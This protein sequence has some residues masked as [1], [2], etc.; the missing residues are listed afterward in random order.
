MAG[1]VTTLFVTHNMNTIASLC[2]RAYMFDT[3]KIHTEGAPRHV[4][5]SYHSLLR[6]REHAKQGKK[7]PKHEKKPDKPAAVKQPDPA[8]AQTQEG[9][10]RYGLGTAKIV[11]Y[12]VYDHEGMET[13]A[14]E[15]GKPFSVWMRV[16]FAGDVENPCF[17]MML[18][19]PQG[20]NLLGI[21]SFHE[22]RMHFGAKKDG[23]EVDVIF[24]GDM[25]LNPGNY[26]LNLGVSDHVTDH[27]F[28][29]LD[30]RNPVAILE[31]YG[32]AFSYG[33]IHNQGRIVVE[34]S[35]L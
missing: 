19:N 11:D 30:A 7:T 29:S 14:I 23:D 27:E 16:T 32:K 22:R 21:H 12:R 18:R 13:C 26:T 35:E 31:V 24:E 6:E 25:L 33:L 20:Q 34:D 28:K 4:T 2:N 15:T 3:G 5:L 17:G 10:Q 1:G 8:K 9:E